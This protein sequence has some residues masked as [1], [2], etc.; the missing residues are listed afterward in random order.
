[1]LTK[2]VVGF[3]ALIRWQHPTLGYVSPAQ[4]IPIAEKTGMIKAIGRQV[5]SKSCS[6]MASWRSVDPRF[7][8]LKLSV[9]LS[10]LQ[11]QQRDFIQSILNILSES[12]LP[13]ADLCLEVTESVIMENPKPVSYTHLTLPTTPYV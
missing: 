13:A 7:S 6:Q 2:Q 12:G 8:N 9:N 4:F 1:M 11:I 5:L 3:E 10:S